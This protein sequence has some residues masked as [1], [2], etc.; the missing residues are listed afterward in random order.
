M[1]KRPLALAVFGTRPEA[2]KL[3]PVIGALRARPE[4]EVRVAATGQHREMLDQVLAVFDLKP[5]Y[6]LNLMQPGQ[7]LSDLT[8]RILREIQP[9]LL[10]EQPRLLLVQGDTA[11]AFAAALAA[12]YR[13]IPVAHVEAGLRTGDKYSPWP[14]EI[15]RR[16]VAVLADWHFA[17]TK[18][19]AANLRREGVP[20]A[21][22]HITGNTVIDAL[23]TVARPD[24]IF[25]SRPLAAWLAAAAAAGRRLLLAT[26]HRRENWGPPLA[27]ICAGLRD[28]LA[29]FPDVSLVLPLH[30]N[31]AAR[32]VITAALGAAA[33]PDRLYLCEPLF[34]AD[35]ANLMGRAHLI[36]TDSGGVQEEAP[37]LGKPLVVARD[38]TERPEIVARG[39]AMLAGA[40]GAAVREAVRRLLTDEKFYARAAAAGNPYGDGRA[41]GRIAAVLA[42]VLGGT[43]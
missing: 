26:L 6:D 22:I 40:S 28:I 30:K 39:G 24:Y 10:A 3:A 1:E 11:T 34:Y 19:A 25:Q 42:A 38:T 29:E 8:G 33:P 20:A 35:F 12:F 37:S 21:R 2:I 9:L 17:P 41:A 7:E 36:V 5:D 13:R 27:D 32:D 23:L 31:P 18:T 16:L 4:M 14:E 43:D 15:N